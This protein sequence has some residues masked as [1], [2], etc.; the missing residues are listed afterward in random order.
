[1][2]VVASVYRGGGGGAAAGGRSAGDGEKAVNHARR[3]IDT[4]PDP[5]LH[6]RDR[7]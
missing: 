1:M 3:V 4:V 7:V 6:F 2:S 5:S